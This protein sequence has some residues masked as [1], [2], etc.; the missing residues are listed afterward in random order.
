VLAEA[1]AAH[2]TQLVI[3][4]VLA[5]VPDKPMHNQELHPVVLEIPL[6]QVPVKVIRAELD[7]EQT[8]RT[9]MQ[10]VAEEPDQWDPMQHLVQPEQA[11]QE[12]YL[13]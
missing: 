2:L 3:M 8:V 12:H 1:A 9:I 5:V 13:P 4:E 10:G 6:V 11:E 7:N